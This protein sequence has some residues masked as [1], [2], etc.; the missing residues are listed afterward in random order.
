MIVAL[1]RAS[2]ILLHPTCLPGPYGVGSLNR[3]AYAWLDFL[4]DAGQKF[5][6]VLP[7]GPT[8]YGDSPYQSPSTFAGNPYLI[9]LENLQE[10]GLLG[11]SELSSAP[12]LAE[13]KVNYCALY[14]WKLPLLRRMAQRQVKSAPAEFHQFCARQPWLDDYALFMALKEQQN[15]KSWQQ[16]PLPLR[17]R[18]RQALEQARQQLASPI[19]CEKYLQWLFFRQWESLRAYARRRGIQVVGDV[20]IFVAMDSA[21]TWCHPQLF[22][23]DEH[24]QPR[25]VA[26]VPPD[27]FSPTGQLWG[28]PLYAWK[29]HR[30]QNYA[31][32]VERAR[33]ALA[34]F[35][36][37][38]IDHF[39]GFAAYWRVPAKAKTAQK[40]RWVKGPGTTFF[41]A[42]LRELG[43]ARIIA[44]DLGE[45]TPD[46]L[47]LRD[48]F[49][50]PGMKILQFAFGSGANNPFL[51]H[52]F[53]S[54]NFVA[55]SGT[56]D[57]DTVRGWWEAA[58]EAA[59]AH[60]KAYFGPSE[61]PISQTLCRA[62]LAS[63]AK[64]AILPLQDVLDLPTEARMNFPGRSF[65]NWTWRLLPNQ[66][67]ARHRDQLRTWSKLYLR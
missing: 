47:A 23:F 54:T 21:D 44:E 24:L 13:G 35:D 61:E 66:L 39:R 12:K 53:E 51:P 34:R 3:S 10:E 31:W 4:A 67:E 16:W 59:K 22:D 57:N 17:R 49:G 65:D 32:W 41:Q 25:S 45:I 11:P 27:Y 64:L 19:E 1:P 46:V 55:Y 2:G 36:W 33:A 14:E 50:L 8:S 26:G 20:P 42:L 9:G 58:D 15:Q 30:Q 7:L 48:R 56:H 6:Q 38:R 52:N 28:N 37:V 18:E 63:V 29:E 43:E 60:L 5:W 40:G 62:T